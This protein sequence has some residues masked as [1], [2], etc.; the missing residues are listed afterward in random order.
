[1]GEL[2]MKILEVAD[3]S[4]E[5]CVNRITECLANLDICFEVDLANKQVRIDGCD[6]C[7]IKAQSALLEIG[8]EAILVE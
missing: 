1:M 6:N 8:Y 2:S 5:H 3:M 4:C 7:V